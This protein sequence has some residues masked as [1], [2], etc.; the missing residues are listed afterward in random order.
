M[1]S[2]PPQKNEMTVQ[3]MKD[4]SERLDELSTRGDT[5]NTVVE[6]L[7]DAYDDRGALMLEAVESVLYAALKDLKGLEKEA[8]AGVKEHEPL[9]WPDIDK[10]T[11]ARM[12]NKVLE[13]I[14]TQKGFAGL[15]VSGQVVG[16]WKPV[17]MDE[18]EAWKASHL[19]PHQTRDELGT[20]RDYFRE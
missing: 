7:L 10:E 17:D 15:S 19:I 18:L 3:L 4:V 14:Q 5:Y 13:L 8:F 9:M 1:E 2:T 12:T 11:A 16:W 20:G 6:K